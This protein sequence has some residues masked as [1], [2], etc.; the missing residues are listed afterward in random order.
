VTWD[1]KNI[2]RGTMAILL[3]VGIAW[4]AAS[5]VPAEQALARTQRPPSP[6][7]GFAAPDFSLATQDG[8]SVNLA[9]LRGQ[10]VLVNFW[11]TWCP[12]CRAEMPAIQQV[13][14]KYRD[15]G[16]TVL[17]I[18]VQEGDAQVASFADQNGLTIPILI[19]H[20]GTVS[21]RYQVKAMPSTFFID[22]NGVIQEVTLG[23][24]MSVA[25]IESQVTGLLNSTGGE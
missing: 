4:I 23:G 11:A 17:A 18:D 20:D 19:D 12:P 6:Q 22:Q 25:F 21:N 3:V 5:R 2:W 13:Y 15:Q 1:N 10:V 24:P 14:D 9:N 16:F 8:E 7:T